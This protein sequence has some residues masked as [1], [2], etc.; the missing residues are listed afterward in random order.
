MALADFLSYLLPVVHADAQVSQAHEEADTA[1][2]ES[3]DTA[4]AA[5]VP[6]LGPEVDAGEPEGEEKEEEE[7]EPEDVG[8]AF[9]LF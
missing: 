7:P 9:F 2:P 4:E 8:F 6:E 1:N 5:D 3:K